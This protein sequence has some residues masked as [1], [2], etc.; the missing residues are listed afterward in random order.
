MVTVPSAVGVGIASFEWV[1]YAAVQHMV[2]GGG[3]VTGRGD[4]KSVIY[5]R[6]RYGQPCGINNVP[7]CDRVRQCNCVGMC[8]RR[9]DWPA[10]SVL[11]GPPCWN[12]RLDKVRRPVSPVGVGRLD[13]KLE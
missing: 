4:S 13:K 12:R 1:L 9:V 3:R 6:C 2:S 11:D 10:T 7:V 8:T 5:R